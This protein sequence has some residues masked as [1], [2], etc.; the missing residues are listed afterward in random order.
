M[1]IAQETFNN[2][3]GDWFGPSATAHIVQKTIDKN[4]DHDFLGG[5]RAYVAKDGTVYKGDIYEM[6]KI[7]KDA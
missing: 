1:E 3:P 6:C 7:K 5:L 2:K 4:R